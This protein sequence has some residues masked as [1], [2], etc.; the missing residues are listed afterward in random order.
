MAKRIAKKMVESA[1][2]ILIALSLFNAVPAQ[3]VAKEQ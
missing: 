2:S 1:V 3:E